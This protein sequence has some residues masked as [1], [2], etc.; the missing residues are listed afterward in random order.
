MT[1]KRLHVGVY[2][3]DACIQNATQIP[4][5]W[6]EVITPGCSQLFMKWTMNMYKV[7]GR[8]SMVCEGA[9]WWGGWG[10]Q[11]LTMRFHFFITRVSKI[12]LNGQQGESGGKC[13]SQCITWCSWPQGLQSG[14]DLRSGD[15]LKFQI[16][17]HQA[18]AKSVVAYLLN[19]LL[20]NSCT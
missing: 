4:C 7:S 12:R 2:A 17:E 5:F 3:N 1:G 20:T 18:P 9:P 15:F 19:S 11:V 16:W 14:L 6:S 10:Q 8:N 13:E